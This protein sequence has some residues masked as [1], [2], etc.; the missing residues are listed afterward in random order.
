M[1]QMLERLNKIYPN[2]GYVSIP[3]YKPEVF[4]G[5]K[6]DSAFDTKVALNRWNTKP[7]S[8]EDAQDWVSKGNRIGWVVPKG[9]VVVD[10]DN[11]DDARSQ[12]YLEKLLEKFE[13][14]MN[15]S[16]IDMPEVI[17]SIS[18]GMAEYPKERKDYANADAIRDEL[19]NEGIKLVDTPNGVVYEIL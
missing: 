14:G 4:E 11:K 18:F 7:L 15:Y 16:L 12:E 5:R 8:Y 6:Y 10:I 2:C 17:L 19:L 1:D 3:A 13:D 9:Y